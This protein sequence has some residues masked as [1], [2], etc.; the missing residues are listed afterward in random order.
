MEKEERKIRAGK[1]EGKTRYIRAKWGYLS[2][3]NIRV[4]LSSLLCNLPNSVT[5]QF[6]SG[7]YFFLL[8]LKGAMKSEINNT[9]Y[10]Y[11]T[12]SRETRS[13]GSASTGVVNSRYD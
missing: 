3:W 13:R 1:R 6:L 4:D 11:S 12:S 10:V 9:R 5:R 2:Q 7:L 8:L